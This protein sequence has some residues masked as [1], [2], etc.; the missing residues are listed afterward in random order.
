[1]KYQSIQTVEAEGGAPV[2][3][4]LQQSN[5]KSSIYATVLRR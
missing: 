5:Q 3:Q 4:N 1:M 2:L